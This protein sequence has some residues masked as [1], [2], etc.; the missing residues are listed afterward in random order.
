MKPDAKTLIKWSNESRVVCS[1]CGRSEREI[2]IAIEAM[3]PKVK[4]ETVITEEIKEKMQSW[5][6]AF[7]EYA[8][9]KT[10]NQL[11]GVF[12]V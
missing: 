8:G 10:H 2:K 6:K 1:C 11:K 12:D 9:Y 7:L 3:W 4:P 5:A